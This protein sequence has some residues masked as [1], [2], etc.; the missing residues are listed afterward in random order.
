MFELIENGDLKYYIVPMFEKTGAVHH[1]FSTRMGGVSEG[2]YYSM[3]LRSHSG[4]DWNRVLENF[5]IISDTL[6]IERDRLVLSKQVH[7]DK[8][9]DVDET[10]IGNGILYENKFTSADALIT[11]KKHVPIAVFSADCVPVLFLDNKNG[12]IAAAHS[13]WRGTVKRIAQKTAEKMIAE[14]GS[15]P[16]DILVAIGPS[17]Q[18]DCF[19]VGDDVAEIFINEF[20]DDTAKKYGE[21][22]HVSM[23][24]AIIKQL[25]EMGIL[26]ENIDNSGICTACNT[27]LLYSHRKMGNERGNLGAFLELI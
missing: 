4:D 16:A 3:N 24:R 20:G 5:R 14:Y 18:E 6:G 21:R 19:E 2:C 1:G 26:R 10:H 13:G 12:V 25:T 15:N 22:Y 9:V 11:N 8:V 7:E 23:Q 17:I 27:D